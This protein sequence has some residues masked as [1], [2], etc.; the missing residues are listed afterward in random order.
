MRESKEKFYKISCKYILCKKGYIIYS[1]VF[2]IIVSMSKHSIQNLFFFS[3]KN[4]IFNFYFYRNL[5]FQSFYSFSTI[6]TKRF[7]ITI[8]KMRESTVTTKAD[9]NG[10]RHSGCPALLRDAKRSSILQI[11]IIDI[12]RREIK[13]VITFVRTACSVTAAFCSAAIWR[14]RLEAPRHRTEV[15]NRQNQ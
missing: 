7:K 8:D 6:K 9:G 10:S 1:Q 3:L 5:H 13:Y 15:V 11:L 12:P 4:V 2:K 14:E